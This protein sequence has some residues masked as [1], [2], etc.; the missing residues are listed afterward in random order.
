MYDGALE[1][2]KPLRVLLV[3][4]NNFARYPTLAIGMLAAVLRRDGIEVG[5]LSP[6]AIGIPGVPR[7]A[8]VGALGRIDQYLRHVTANASV[9]AIR[10][11][12]A[13]LALRRHPI[14]RQEADRILAAFDRAIG[15]GYD[16][17][18][19]SAYLM[20]RGVVEAIAARCASR[21][22]PLGLGGPYF[23]QPEVVDA[24]RAIP[25]VTG[26]LGGEAEPHATRFV[27]ALADGRGLE[28]IPGVSTAHARSGAAPSVPD[29]DAL[30]FADFGDFPWDRYPNRLVPVITGRG[31]GWGRC[32]FCSDVTSSMGRGF[33]SRSAAH[34]HAELAHQAR[35]H[36]TSC[37]VFTDLKL[38]SDLAA[39]YGLLEG[40]QRAVP[41]MR[42]VGA[43]HADR[44]VEN[45][46]EAPRLKEAAA[47]GMVRLTTG[48][49]SGSQRILDA[50]HKG[51]DVGRIDRM[52]RDAWEAGISVRLTMILGYPGEEP[53]DVAASAAF[54]ER[55]ERFIGR[56]L[57]NRFA[58][59]TGTR[60]Q[61]R[62]RRGFAR[63]ETLQDLAEDPVSAVWPH[64]YG[65]AG[66]RAYRRAVWRLLGAAH[67]INRRTLHLSAAAF[68][69]VM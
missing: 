39:W 38:N 51:A 56:V 63:R 53:E 48:L 46:L 42:W 6:L 29:L 30:P 20:Y 4:L 5:V 66:D 45:G 59:I 50:M 33:R 8:R 49:E 7:E 14:G 60:I 47:A 64:R 34:V 1:R 62:L 26:V 36:A 37:F 65:R 32:T 44:R 35:R 40:A 61:R 69:G 27:H 41:G 23:A 55:N 67:A 43:V 13:R 21:R 11:A 52:I 9:P 2:E 68:D 17:V 18:L 57:L 31:C 25:G 22:I 28:E 19:V 24:W 12:R 58:M 10:A 3:D 15:E 16:A 54:L